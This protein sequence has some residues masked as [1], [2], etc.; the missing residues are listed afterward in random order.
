MVLPNPVFDRV[1]ER[2]VCMM[3][4]CI[5]LIQQRRPLTAAMQVNTVTA[6]TDLLILNLPLI[7]IGSVICR[8]QE[9]AGSDLFRVECIAT[10]CNQGNQHCDGN[11]LQWSLFSLETVNVILGETRFSKWVCSSSATTACNVCFPAGS[12]SMISVSPLDS[13]ICCS[14]SCM[15]SSR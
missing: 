1:V 6:G 2:E 12:S 11:S 10:C 3:R 13:R 5:G 4:G 9:V 15:G 8:R 7:D 14:S